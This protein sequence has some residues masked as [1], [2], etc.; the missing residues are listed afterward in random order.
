VAS[1]QG[2]PVGEIVTMVHKA[3]KKANPEEGM[4]TSVLFARKQ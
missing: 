3:L 1:L 2:K 4:E